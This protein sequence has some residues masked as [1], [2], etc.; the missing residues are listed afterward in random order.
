MFLAITIINSQP[1]TKL[2]GE[3]KLA[4]TKYKQVFKYYQE[5]DGK[6]SN[7]PEAKAC[8]LNIPYLYIQGCDETQKMLKK[9]RT[10]ID[11]SIDGQDD[12]NDIGNNK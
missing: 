3:T 5:K 7:I 9:F 1:G 11:L 8:K 12:D 6:E 2:I 10:Q 4:V